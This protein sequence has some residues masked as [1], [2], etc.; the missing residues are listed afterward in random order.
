MPSSTWPDRLARAFAILR[1]AVLVLYSVMLF[2]EPEK[3]VAGSSTEPAWT[4]AL[5]Y[6]TYRSASYLD[7][8]DFNAL[9]A[10]LIS[11]SPRPTFGCRWR[12][13]RKKKT[14]WHLSGATGF[15][16]AWRR[17]ESNPPPEA[18][19]GSGP[20]PSR[21]VFGRSSSRLRRPLLHAE[22]C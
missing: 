16:A 19:G 17:R 11:G 22:L 2:I 13:R 15:C 10:A 3:M 9:S 21:A 8:F 18:S 7:C 5:M 12:P 1:A 14:P 20:E 6:A 4:L